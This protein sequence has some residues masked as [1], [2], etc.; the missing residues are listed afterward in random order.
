MIKPGEIA[1][2]HGVYQ[3]S[4][5]EPNDMNSD[6]AQTS[7]KRPEQIRDTLRCRPCSPKAI[8]SWQLRASSRIFCTQNECVGTLSL[9]LPIQRLT[10][11]PPG[12]TI[13]LSNLISPLDGRS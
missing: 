2:P 3:D 10:R 7:Y 12:L 6:E 9:A 5:A 11:L 4:G 8:F 13:R 1:H